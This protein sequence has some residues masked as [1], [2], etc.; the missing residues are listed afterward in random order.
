MLTLQQIK[1][2]P[3]EVVE[4]HDMSVIRFR[5]PY[6]AMNAAMKLTKDFD[7]QLVERNFDNTCSLTLSIN[8]DSA[9]ML[10]ARIADIDGATLYD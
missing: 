7:V 2:N 5:F 9:P 4:R 6:A 10:R 3:A 8:A 1:S